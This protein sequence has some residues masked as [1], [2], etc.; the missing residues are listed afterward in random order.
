MN[1]KPSTEILLCPTDEAQSELPLVVEGVQRYVW[2][3]KFGSMLIEV[4]DNRVFVN[5]QQVELMPL[6]AKG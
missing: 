6:P 3:G 5:G 2:E 1:K 4:E